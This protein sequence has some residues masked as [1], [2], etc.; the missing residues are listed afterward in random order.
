MPEART[1]ISV[2]KLD[3][4]SKRV[5]SKLKGQEGVILSPLMIGFSCRA[6][7]LASTY[8]PRGTYQKSNREPV[9]WHRFPLRAHCSFSGS[10][11]CCVVMYEFILRYSRGQEHRTMRRS[12]E[13]WKVCMDMC[14]NLFNSTPSH[15]C[16]NDTV[17]Q[18]RIVL[19]ADSVLSKSLQQR[20][21]LRYQCHCLCR[22]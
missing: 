3:H 18:S 2:A 21:R 1:H 12:S 5:K 10:Q 9:L 11:T 19:G 22:P 15:S 20:I 4:R 16:A 17:V 13:P 6:A 8:K 14:N 7:T